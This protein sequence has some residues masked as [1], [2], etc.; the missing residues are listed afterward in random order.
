MFKIPRQPSWPPAID[1]ATVR[2]TLHY[3]K[4]DMRRV[5]GLEKAAGAIEA[6]IVEIDNA[7]VRHTPIDYSAINSKFLP[8][9]QK[10]VNRR[11]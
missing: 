1:L 2:E 6:A 10:G 3:M 11:S 4:V 7:G 5:P 8:V 9:W